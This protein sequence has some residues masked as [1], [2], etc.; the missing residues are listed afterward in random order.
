MPAPGFFSLK[1]A[2]SP[3]AFCIMVPKREASATRT[4]RI[5]PSTVR[6]VKRLKHFRQRRGRERIAVQHQP[7]RRVFSRAANR[8]Q[9]SARRAER[10]GF[11]NA[12]HADIFHRLRLKMSGDGFRQMAGG[13][14]HAADFLR[15]QITDDPFEKRPATRPAPSA[16]A[17]PQQMPDAPA[18]TAGEDDGGDLFWR[19]VDGINHGDTA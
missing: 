14:N 7:C 15:G 1:P 12:I 9:K 5:A 8:V 18:K 3:R 17:N 2:S 19:N 11:R 13:Q 6:F 16:W 10:F 4:P